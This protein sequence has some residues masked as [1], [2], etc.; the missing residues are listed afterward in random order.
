ML[1]L[2]RRN[3]IS[4]LSMATGAALWW[5]TPFGAL[6]AAAESR[7]P[8]HRLWSEMV[9]HQ[10]GLKAGRDPNDRR[11]ATLVLEEASVRE[12]G[13]DPH[14]PKNLRPAATSLLFSS[15]AAAELTNETYTLSHS[16]RGEVQLYLHRM[17]RSDYPDSMIYEAVLN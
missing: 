13:N 16:R 6:P 10:F 3:L 1:S 15:V 2:T 8:E 7:N 12:Y 9:G 11:R 14:R 17:I 5:L 4:R